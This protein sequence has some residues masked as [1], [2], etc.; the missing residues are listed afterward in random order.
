MCFFTDTCML[1][2]MDTCMLAVMD[3]CML[4]VMGCDDKGVKI[5]SVILQDLCRLLRAENQWFPLVT[6]SQLLKIALFLTFIYN[7]KKCVFL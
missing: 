5:I 1:A 7:Q 3:T 6:K 4:A 2:V